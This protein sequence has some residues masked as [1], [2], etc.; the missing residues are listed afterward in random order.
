MGVVTGVIGC[1]QALE[2]IKI[3]LMSDVN[4]YCIPESNEALKVSS[5]MMVIFDALSGRF[6]NI[7]LRPRRT[8]ANDVSFTH[9]LYSIPI[10]A[11]HPLYH[12]LLTYALIE[13][14]CIL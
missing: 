11:R 12:G 14:L 9:I 7:K 13:V 4:S 6:R 8:E 3:I 10:R 1:L 2:T 5:G